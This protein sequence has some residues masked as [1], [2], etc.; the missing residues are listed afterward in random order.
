[1]NCLIVFTIHLPEL[2]WSLS[3]AE[4]KLKDLVLVRAV[5]WYDLGLQLGM[6]DAELDVIEENNPRDL[7]TC[8]RE[9]FKVWLRNTSSPSYQQLVE[10]LQAVGEINEAD[11]LCKKYGTWLY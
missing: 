9:M 8:Q 1:M 4:P 11:H 10:A 5:K 6:E 7:S 3:L 2:M